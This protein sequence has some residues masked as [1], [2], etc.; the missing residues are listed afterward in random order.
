MKN[1]TANILIVD[2]NVDNLNVLAGM[3][4]EQNYKVRRA[5]SGSIA[6]RAIQASIPDLILLD[7]V[8]PDMT[9]YD[10][11]S[12]LK[13]DRLT[14]DIPIIFISSL[15]DTEDK[16]KA[17]TVGGADYVSKPFEMAEVC[18]RIRNQL[19]IKFAKAE[20]EALNADLEK[21]VQERTAELTS[22]T[23]NLEQQI[24]ERQKAELALRHS[25][26]R[27]R[28]MI[29][30]ASDLILVLDPDGVVHYSSPS[31]EKNLGYLPVDLCGS[32][33]WQW[34]HPQD[35][36]KVTHLFAEVIA[37]NN[38]VAMPLEVRW[39]HQDGSWC[40][41]EAIAQQFSD[42]TGFSGIVVNAR[43]V[44]ERQKME[45]IQRDLEREQE[46]SDLKLRFFSMASHEFRTPLSVILMAAQILESSESKAL[47][48]KQQRNIQRIHSSAQYLK[49]MLADVLDIARLEAQQMEFNPR[50]V[51][52]QAICDRILDAQQSLYGGVPRIRLTYNGLLSEITIDPNL[53][54][55]ILTNLL[56]NALKYS[57]PEKLVQVRVTQEPQHIQLIIADQ[58]I[59]I[60]K[61]NQDRL[62][63][64]F[65]RGDNVGEIEGSGLGLA[66]VRKCVDLHGG[67]L[68]FVSDGAGTTF[69]VQ[70][71][72][73]S[74]LHQ[75]DPIIKQIVA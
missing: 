10:I 51:C 41:L 22:V 38:F 29:E 33:L 66:I 15:N 16:V 34:L 44:T 63:E 54:Q 65:H 40:T 19:A 39:R 71:P 35:Q 43:D 48:A 11:C 72:I 62:F 50:P 46:L 31:V 12:Q 47:D 4:A 21:R 9:G 36:P 25:E 56:T 7:I 45:A 61:L 2:D 1:S 70:L 5:I 23:V 24:Q 55:S 8:L 67:D 59:G 69:T 37:D 6:L 75:T 68:S 53:F 20:I 52:L 27:F 30:N 64:A 32:T 17:F 58:G 18:A 60:P 42:T 74:I 13:Q 49:K 26:S 28:A 14:Q 73:Q 57:P 3:L